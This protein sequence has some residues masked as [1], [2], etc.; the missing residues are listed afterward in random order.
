MT[1][2]CYGLFL[3]LGSLGGQRTVRK[4][5]RRKSHPVSTIWLFHMC[6]HYPCQEQAS[7]WA[8]AADK[9]ILSSIY[10]WKD[11]PLTGFKILN[12]PPA[13]CISENRLTVEGNVG[14]P[15][16]QLFRN[17]KQAAVINLVSSEKVADTQMKMENQRDKLPKHCQHT[18]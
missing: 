9:S 3:N 1:V 6:T 16:A 15:A 5:R 4:T 13:Y 11:I 2:E 10:R 12:W 17:S 8:Q 14:G 7:L 18:I